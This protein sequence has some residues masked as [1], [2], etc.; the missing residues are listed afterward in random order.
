VS[1]FNVFIRPVPQSRR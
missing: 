1:A